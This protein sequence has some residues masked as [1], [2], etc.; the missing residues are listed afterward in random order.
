MFVLFKEKR[1][2]REN[3]G[4]NRSLCRRAIRRHLILF[5]SYRVSEYS[6]NSQLWFVCELQLGDNAS[7]QLLCHPSYYCAKDRGC[8]LRD[9]TNGTHEHDQSI[10]L[11]KRPRDKD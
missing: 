4:S 7:S 6:G 9:K 10:S 1:E 3:K 8:M 5:V 2:R 11:D